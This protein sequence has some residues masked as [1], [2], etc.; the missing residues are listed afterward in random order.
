MSIR[1]ALESNEATKLCHHNCRRLNKLAAVVVEPCA[2]T[3]SK[4]YIFIFCLSGQ[5]KVS[6]AL[7]NDQLAIHYSKPGLRSVKKNLLAL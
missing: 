5:N 3:S 1:Q 2:L 7:K 4:I 6:N